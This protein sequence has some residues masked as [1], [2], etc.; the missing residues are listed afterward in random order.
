MYA[1][2][3]KKDMDKK[4]WEFCSKISGYKNLGKSGFGIG[5]GNSVAFS[6]PTIDGIAPMG[7]TPLNDE[8]LRE[9]D[10]YCKAVKHYPQPFEEK[11]LE[12]AKKE[13]LPEG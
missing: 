13:T 4:E 3:V 8:E 10:L 12:D 11:T 5:E 1:T 6:M 9:Y 2:F 7:Y